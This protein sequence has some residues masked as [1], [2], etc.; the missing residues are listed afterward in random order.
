MHLYA[1]VKT[2]FPFFFT[3]FPWLLLWA[4]LSTC[5]RTVRSTHRKF[6]FPHFFDIT[7]ILTLSFTINGERG[8]VWFYVVHGYMWFYMICESILCRTIR[9]WYVPY[10]MWNTG[11]HHELRRGMYSSTFSVVPLLVSSYKSAIS[12]EWSVC[13]WKCV[14]TK[15][16]YAIVSHF[17]RI[18]SFFF[19][20][21]VY[22]LGRLSSFI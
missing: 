16:L 19:P 8:Q 2:L 7:L 13:Q 3:G 12:N 4:T 5:I 22:D 14:I 18:A 10:M 15:R 21:G 6:K 17:D 9:S 11:I 20:L 1:T